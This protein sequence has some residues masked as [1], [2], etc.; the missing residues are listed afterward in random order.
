MQIAIAILVA[1]A[2]QGI[3]YIKRLVKNFKARVLSYPNSIFE[4]EPC[5]V[6]TLTE[7]NDIE[8]LKKASLIITPN[9]YNEGVLYDVVPNT[10]LGD[11]NAV[12]A[13]TA[14]RVNSSGLIEVVPRNLLTY[15][16]DFTNADWVKLNC[17]IT[18]NNTISPDGNL[19]ASKLTSNNTGNFLYNAVSATD[20]IYTFSC[21]VKKLDTD[22]I[23]ISVTDFATGSSFGIFNFTTGLF[24]SV[25]NGGSWT[26]TTANATNLQNGWFKISLTSQKNAGT[27]ISSRIDSFANGTSV[28]IYGAQTEQGSTATTYFPTTTRLNI[29][30]I[31]YT[32]GSCP[33]LLV[34]PQRTNYQTNSNLFTSWTAP[35]DG[36]TLTPNTTDTLSPSGNND[37]TKMTQTGGN[38][39]IFDVVTLPSGVS[40]YS[41]YVKSGTGSV[42]TLLTSNLTFFLTYNLITKTITTYNGTGTITELQN[43]WFKITATGTQSTLE[44]VQIRSE[45]NNGE[46]LYIYGAQ[47]E[48][49]VYPTSYIPT[50]ATSVTRN[51]DVISKT[52]ISSLIGQTEGTLFVDIDLTHSNTTGGV[53]YLMQIYKDTSSRIILFRNSFGNLSFYFLQTGIVFNYESVV[54][55]NSRHKIAFAYKS[56][57]SAF[58]ID[59]IQ[60][61]LNIDTFSLFSSLSELHLAMN[62]D[63]GTQQEIGDYAYNS[64]QLYKTRLSNT[65]LAS[66]T[67]L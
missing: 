63:G 37:S 12:R 31:D 43:G 47:F 67:S 55:S 20:G 38:K 5:L 56:G 14:T 7:L 59:G 44:V 60:I 10:T 49:G 26:N 22:T 65:E 33:S 58:Y 50:V 54:N 21:F 13:T 57:N 1:N 15:S 3:S 9:A 23:N 40:T 66:L 32:N 45:N 29:P 16:N 36:V 6:A 51:A 17:S 52:G 35:S 39:R 46:T 19:N 4:A 34:E 48:A 25:V 24:A 8:L 28:Y 61:A 11:M 18:A 64:A 42:I 62:Y 27:V 2:N 30:R 53:Q 41:L